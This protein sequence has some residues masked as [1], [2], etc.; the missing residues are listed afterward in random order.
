L[1][2]CSVFSFFLKEPLSI[3]SETLALV[4]EAV[5]TGSLCALPALFLHFFLVFPEKKSILRHGV[6][7]YAVLYAP[8]CVFFVW[9][10]PLLLRSP[11][12]VQT[13]AA[14]VE[15]F[16]S[17]LAA[18]FLVSLL[19]A[20]IAFVHSYIKT[21]S[22]VSKRKL[23]V[24][25][26]G[27]ICGVV[28]VSTVTLA[29]NL[30]PAAQIPAERYAFLALLLVPGS[31]GYAIVRYHMFNIDVAVRKSLM[32]SLL[33]AFL[34]AV[35]LAMV[36]GL[37]RLVHSYFGYGSISMSI[38]SLFVIA[39]I[40][41]PA[42][43]R[44]QSIVDTLFHRRR[45]DFQSALRR[46]TRKLTESVEP[47]EVGNVVAE[48]LAVTL[49]VSSVFVLTYKENTLA[50]LA[51]S[52]PGARSGFTGPITLSDEAMDF[53]RKLQRA[54]FLM[55]ELREDS[56]RGV[57]QEVYDG[58]ARPP[59]NIIVPLLREAGS[60]G[61]VAVGEPRSGEWFS[62]QDLALL[63]TVARHAAA[64]LENAR[65]H[66]EA[67]E[68][69]RLQQEMD[70]ARSIQQALLPTEDPLIPTLDVSGKTIPSFAVGGDYFDYVAIDGNRFG[71]ALGDVSGR[72][73][74][75]ALVMAAAQGAF[76]AEAEKEF[77]PAEIVR[78]VNYRICE[79]NKPEKFL[80]FFYGVIDVR[81][82]R[83]AY[84]NAGL[85]PPLILRQNGEIDKL[86]RG[87]LLVGV[88]KEAAYDTG[89]VALARDD[90]LLLFS[91]GLTEASDGAAF[92]G[93]GRVL[94]L[95]H[96]HRKLRARLIKEK[97]IDAAKQHAHKPLDDDLTLVVI[98][99]L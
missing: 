91:D 16:E 63:E 73:V 66:K 1:L 78:R 37:G 4:H 35:Y 46:I 70:V 54:V 96:E 79:L 47:E 42:R 26:W 86:D 69:D 12:V 20:A 21:E 89:S 83:I 56:S 9:S 84:C 28:P 17:L 33:T 19:I 44:I 93:E 25:L 3:P 77:S 64:H 59:V 40:F 67:L 11:E 76:R 41:M 39:A 43:D 80:C 82:K 87:G 6:R 7:S 8:A 95:A 57:P 27:T 14:Q 94:S 30:F 81:H 49:K 68:K 32:Y 29:A 10:L 61:L 65:L 5:Y 34:V 85:N 36:Q 62:S 45:Y 51:S 90:I 24:A 2:I 99:I 13:V 55:D 58:F 60:V 72:G 52:G 75:A 88:K 22:L 53:L 48:E 74:A 15:L 71:I 18:Y 92:F 38:I 50:V 97:I 23:R 31:F 98:K